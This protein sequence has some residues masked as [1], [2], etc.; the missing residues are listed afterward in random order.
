VLLAGTVFLLFPSLLPAIYLLSSAFS[1]LICP[2][3]WLPS[4]FN[5]TVSDQVAL[6]SATSLLYCQQRPLL[7]AALPVFLSAHF[8]LL[9]LATFSPLLV[10]TGTFSLPGANNIFSS[11]ASN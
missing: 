10:G 3:C 5:F 2:S 7:S 8:S 4:L 9:L 6:L 11:A 1:N